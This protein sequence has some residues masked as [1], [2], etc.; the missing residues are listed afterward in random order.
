MF[1]FLWKFFLI[2]INC[3][4]FFHFNKKRCFA[5]NSQHTK[6]AGKLSSVWL[7]IVGRANESIEWIESKSQLLL[8]SDRHLLKKNEFVPASKNWNYLLEKRM[9]KILDQLNPVICIHYLAD[10]YINLGNNLI[11]FQFYPSS[12]IC[13]WDHQL[14]EV[15]M[16]IYLWLKLK[17]LIVP[18]SCSSRILM[19]KL[20][21]LTG[22]KPDTRFS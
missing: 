22:N 10:T 7:H 20:F 21:S 9:G 13:K 16:L 17:L 2:D 3:A 1:V 5:E 15:F 11:I 12:V 14:M 8:G 18:P 19:W 6:S 4:I